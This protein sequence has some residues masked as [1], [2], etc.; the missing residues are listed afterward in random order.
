MIDVDEYPILSHG[1]DNNRIFIGVQSFNSC[2]IFQVSKNWVAAQQMFHHRVWNGN[3][4]RSHRVRCD[5]VYIIVEGDT[6]FTQIE[7][8]CRGDVSGRSISHVFQRF[9]SS[10]FVVSHQLVPDPIRQGFLAVAY[11]NIIEAER[12]HQSKIHVQESR[13]IHTVCASG[14]FV[15]VNAIY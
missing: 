2:L 11:K 10:Y 5:V 9:V 12:T 7:V 14:I 3:F 1:S 8:L 6:F 4:D 15:V 13:H